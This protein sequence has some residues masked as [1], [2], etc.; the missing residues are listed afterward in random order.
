MDYQDYYATLGVKKSAS[1]DEIQKSYR[2]QARKYHPD[3]NSS[4]EAEEKFKKL[5]EAYEVLKDPEKRQTY[6]RF[7]HQWK[8]RGGAPPGWQNV[9]V[10]FGGGGGSGF[11][12]FFE[13]LFGGARGAAGGGSPFGGGGFPGGDF[14]G[15]NF[16]GGNP[17]GGG[18]GGSLNQEVT[19]ALTLEEAAQGGQRQITVRD[20]QTGQSASYTVTLPEGV[21]AGQKLRLAGKGLEGPGGQRGDLF[22]KIDLRPHQ[23]FRLDGRDLHADLP[24]TPWQAALGGEASVRT[25][26]G[27]LR[28][29]VPAG[30]SSGRR[31]RL[32]GKGFPDPRATDGDLYLEIKVMVPETLT[33]RERELFEALA[34]ASAF[35]PS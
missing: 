8:Q 6:D 32:R 3:V 13:M 25:L 9:R 5:T 16:G 4:P 20:P 11:S 2:K 23:R 21:R 31:I 15:G 24:V 33:E 1:Q 14:G 29:K 28:V 35:K 18:F 27:T 12:D 22:L 19:L 34:E 7:G 17:F 30:S 10:D 26:K